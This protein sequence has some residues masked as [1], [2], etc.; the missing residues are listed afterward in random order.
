MKKT[1]IFV[2]AAL[3]IIACF[4][5]CT[6][7]EGSDKAYIQKKGVLK[8]GITDY[9]PMDYKDEN[10]EWIGFDADLAR[11]VGDRLGVDV[12]FFVLA[13]WGQ[14]FNELNTK[15]IDAAW[16][17]M[18]ITEE[19]L[20][21]SSCTEPYAV[22]AQVLV[23]KA[24]QIGNY[25][26]P[27]SIKG[28]NLAVEKGSAGEAELQELGIGDYVAVQDQGSALMEVKAGTSDGCVVDITL[29]NAMIGDGTS[30]S[31]LASGL[32]LSSEEFGIAFRK[33][34]DLVEEV[35]RIMDELK[36]DGTLQKL[37]EKYNVALTD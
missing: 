17:G 22:N 16:N 27:E 11:L 7:E 23:M 30:Y 31:D 2:L 8:V 9:A 26:T 24:E 28:L 1:I 37:A 29:A 20:L 14:K 35:N 32:R 34:S 5:G 15:N 33:G 18:T 25:T 10:G 21:N 19:V 3:M 4:A 36:A 12:E 6:R 13:D